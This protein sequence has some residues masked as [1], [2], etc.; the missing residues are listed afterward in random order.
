MP[1]YLIPFAG[2]CLSLYLVGTLMMTVAFV[3]DKKNAHKY[4]NTATGLFCGGYLFNAVASI[5]TVVAFFIFFSN[6]GI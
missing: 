1:Y 5:L 3:L 6:G 2:S 4:G